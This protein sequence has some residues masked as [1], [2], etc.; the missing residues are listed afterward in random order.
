MGLS[1]IRRD[2][3]TRHA[4]GN[5]HLD[6]VKQVTVK[7]VGLQER[8]KCG[9]DLNLCYVWGHF[10]NPSAFWDLAQHGNNY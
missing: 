4:A 7:L 1:T 2:R 3:T 8:R 6:S 10:Q 5:L 9:Q